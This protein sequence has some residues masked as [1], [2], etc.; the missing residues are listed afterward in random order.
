MAGYY[1]RLRSPVNV[2]LKTGV[3]AFIPPKKTLVVSS[4]E[5]G[6]ASLHAMVR[7]GYLVRVAAE[8]APV[9]PVEVLQ[10][11]LS[12]PPSVEAEVEPEEEEE[13]PSIKW[14]KSRLKEHA[15]ELGV[16]YPAGATKSEILEWI[17]DADG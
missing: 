16:E 5:D 17:E 10:P 9:V 3:P 4:E 13:K 11:L 12:S 8:A 1:N 15:A 6:S 14:T 2:T 7:R